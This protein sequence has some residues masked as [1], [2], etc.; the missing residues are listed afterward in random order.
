MLSDH[1]VHKGTRL[2]V[3]PAS[4]RVH[5]EALRMGLVEKFVTAGAVWMNAGW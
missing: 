3:F 5:I 1:K 4:R 2:L